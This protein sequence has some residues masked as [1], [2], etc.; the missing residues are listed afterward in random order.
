[1]L[2][3]RRRREAPKRHGLDT[4]RR[5]LRSAADCQTN[6]GK[7]CYESLRSINSFGFCSSDDGGTVASYL[8]AEVLG[9]ASGVEWR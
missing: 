1:M 8:L 7:D 6:P 3:I 4:S 9:T 5:R 2:R